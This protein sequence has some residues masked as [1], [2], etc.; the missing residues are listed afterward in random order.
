M[1]LELAK[2]GPDPKDMEE[3]V[4]K[5][6]SVLDDLQT[7]FARLLAEHEATQGKLK[8]RMTKLEKKMTDSG[9]AALSEIM[10]PDLATADKKEE[11]E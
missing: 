3:K 5:I 4:V 7:C 1:D 8:K 2:Q 6:G 10:D 9:G 11:K